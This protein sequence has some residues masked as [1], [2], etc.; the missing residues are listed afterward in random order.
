MPPEKQ[1]DAIKRG[2]AEWSKIANIDFEYIGYGDAN[3]DINIYFGYMEHGDGY[4]FD[5]PNG[6]LALEFKTVCDVW[7]RIF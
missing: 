5:G 6:L 3:A 4:P 7:T 1:L 2:F